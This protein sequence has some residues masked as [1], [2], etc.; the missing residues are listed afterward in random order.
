MFG[1]IWKVL[2]KLSQLAEW[3]NKLHHF[4]DPKSDPWHQDRWT[5]LRLAQSPGVRPVSVKL[6]N[7]KKKNRFI[8]NANTIKA[9]WGHRVGSRETHL[10]PC[11][12]SDWQNVL[13]QP[14]TTQLDS[15]WVCLCFTFLHFNKLVEATFQ[16]NVHRGEDFTSLRKPA[17]EYESVLETLGAKGNKQSSRTGGGRNHEVLEEAGGSRERWRKLFFNKTCWYD[18]LSPPLLISPSY[19][20]RTTDLR[21]S[22]VE[23]ISFYFTTHQTDEWC[24]T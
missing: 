4:L 3:C 13:Y 11:R 6:S 19:C 2:N 22:W 16:R 1:H 14:A 21:G 15:F 20:E 10:H 17:T 7:K 8:S 12:D 9:K 18:P 23:W 24:N 5:G